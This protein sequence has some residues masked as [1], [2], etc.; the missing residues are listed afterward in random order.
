MVSRQFR[1][2][3]TVGSSPAA[4]TKNESSPMDC[5]FVFGTMCSARAERDAHI[6]RDAAVGSDVR[7]AREKEHITSLCAFAQYITVHKHDI[8]CPKG[9]ISLFTNFKLCAI[10][11]VKERCYYGRI[12]AP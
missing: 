9:Q 8:T 11:W 5:F 10:I 1:V 2:L 12:Q 6:V 4:S 3:E 7:Y